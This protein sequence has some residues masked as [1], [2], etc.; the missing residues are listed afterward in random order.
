MESENIKK[1]VKKTVLSTHIILCILIYIYKLKNIINN[2][3]TSNISQS[4]NNNSS[5][6]MNLK[7]ITEMGVDIVSK[8]Y[9]GLF[10]RLLPYS[11]KIFSGLTKFK[12]KMR[13]ENN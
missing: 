1:N 2:N 3:N 11:Q 12:E 7:K 4:S 8:N 6:L 10:F 13:T 5:R 9:S